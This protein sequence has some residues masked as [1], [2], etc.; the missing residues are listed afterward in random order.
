MDAYSPHLTD[1]LFPYRAAASGFVDTPTCG[2]TGCPD[3]HTM[4]SSSFSSQAATIERSPPSVKLEAQEDC[5]AFAAAAPAP[6]VATRSP[7]PV[8]IALPRL[9]M[10]SPSIRRRISTAQ[11]VRS[12]P[13]PRTP[14]PAGPGPSRVARGTSSPSSDSDAS[15]STVDEM[16]VKVASP[17]VSV[18]SLLRRPTRRMRSSQSPTAVLPIPVGKREGSEDSMSAA[19]RRAIEK[20]PF[21]ACLFCRGR[22]IACAPIPVK[23]GEDKCCKYVPFDYPLP[24]S[25]LT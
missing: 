10:T 25:V 5:A 17:V 11:Q 13:V 9:V 2:E 8:A 3:V 24:L 21:V 1:G 7:S 20:R 16:P 14:P 6:F 15:G 19:K 22:K 23:E 4:A 18:A 12:P